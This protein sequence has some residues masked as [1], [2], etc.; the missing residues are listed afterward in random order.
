MYKSISKLIK[1]IKS[2]VSYGTNFTKDKIVQKQILKANFFYISFCLYLV[3]ISIYNF[4]NGKPLLAIA[5]NV[6]ILILILNHFLFRIFKK[7]QLYCFL[8][9]SIFTSVLCLALLNGAYN[10][11]GVI[12]VGIVIIAIMN[13]SGLKTGTILAILILIFELFIFL[14][15]SKFPWIYNYPDLMDEMFIR[16]ICAHFGVFTFTYI[17][18][19]KQND[20]LIKLNRE[21]EEKD[22]LF[23]NLVHDIKTPLTIIH[24]S[25]DKCIAY[26]N[27]E[28]SS[29][30]LKSNIIRMEKN[31]LNILDIDR[32][33]KGLF[34]KDNKHVSNIS[35]ITLEICKM[36]YEYASSRGITINTKLK[37]DLYVEIDETSYMEILYNLLDNAIKY[38][39]S[40]G[41]IS[42]SLSADYTNVIL[43]VEDSGIGIAESEKEKIFEKYY[44]ANKRI[45]NYYGLGIGLSFAKRI[46][47]AF[48]S[49]ISFDSTLDEGSVFTVQFPKSN[50]STTQNS[51][52]CKE[53]LIPKKPVIY[54]EIEINE[55]MKTILI[56]EDNNDLLSILI[57]SF[58]DKYN[59]LIGKNGKEGLEKYNNNKNNID[60]IITDIMMPVMSGR[61]FVDKIRSSDNELTTPVIFLTAK[62]DSL[63]V[64][65]H[66]SLGA[67]DY[68]EKPFFIDKLLE[69]VNSIINLIDN[70]KNMMIQSIG[71]DLQSYITGN[72]KIHSK[73]IVK[74]DLLR[75][76]S[77]TKKEESIIED[78][79]KGHSN[80]EIATKHDISLN[81]V[82]THIY[83][84]YK[85]CDVKNSTSLIKLFYH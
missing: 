23:L 63:E 39:K 42:V 3:F 28:E 76:L 75:S 31:I 13:L 11:S 9:A 20:L 15:N 67:V 55:N 53:L 59:V 72:L 60:I 57:S 16:F 5:A 44:Q 27:D 82:K 77:I 78:I 30:L 17:S 71:N 56:V 49:T 24:N 62:S 33:E 22:H 26:S 84:I 64:L 43:E 1:I 14:Y 73:N 50:L 61:E 12:A 81:T 51:D 18:I 2:H 34:N 74:S 52:T 4:T 29:E 69:Q 79:S 32:F 45:G 54:D 37:E 36:F 35:I 48:N 85:K 8:M 41:N 83:R 38:T 25:I 19:K 40:G 10:G 6:D 68:I 7:I 70:R 66:L 65:D 58:K 47:E 21:K 80:K 46:C